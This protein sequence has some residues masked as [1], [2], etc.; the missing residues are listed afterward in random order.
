MAGRSSKGRHFGP[1][2][3]ALSVA[4]RLAAERLREAGIG[5]EPLSAADRGPHMLGVVL[6]PAARDR[7]HASLAAAD[8]YAAV[9]G[10]SLRIAPHLHNTL[11]EV[12]RLTAALAAAVAG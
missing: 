2:P 4:T 1:E 7:A 12:E 5:L 9:R 10:D 8:C 6:P 3:D 11:D